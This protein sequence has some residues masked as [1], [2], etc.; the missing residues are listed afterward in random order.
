[1]YRYSYALSNYTGEVDFYVN[2]TGNDGSSSIGKP[3]AFNE[4]EFSLSPIKVDCI[5]L[6][7]WSSINKI[8]KVDFM[9]LDMEGHEL[10]VLKK[11]T[12]LLDSV[13]V[14]YTEVDFE[15][16]REDTCLYNDLRLFLES[17]GFQEIWKR[18]VGHRFG[19][20]LFVKY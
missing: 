11:A 18:A 3:L 9:W 14:I 7:D 20:A 8:T 17:N 2:N 4:K 13:K 16:V 10:Y 12:S 5:T 6:N 1:M 15:K 19:D